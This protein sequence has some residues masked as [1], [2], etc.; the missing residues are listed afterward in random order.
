LPFVGGFGAAHAH[1]GGGVKAWAALLLGA[2]LASA[3]GGRYVP[4]NRD[5]IGLYANVRLATAEGALESDGVY[6][7]KL[8]F[9]GTEELKAAGQGKAAVFQ[10]GSAK[11]EEFTFTGYENGYAGFLFKPAGT[12]QDYFGKTKIALTALDKVFKLTNAENSSAS[13]KGSGELAS[14]LAV[15]AI[16]GIAVGL[17]ALYLVSGFI[18]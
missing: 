4:V 8:V 12:D 17:V 16:I 14:A 18:D 2:S 6:C 1:S 11:V 13:K 9:A 5:S 10:C 3:A 7:D 15:Y